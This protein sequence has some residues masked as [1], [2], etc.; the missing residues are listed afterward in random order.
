M[1]T[2]SAWRWRRGVEDKYH[3]R[4]WSQVVRWMSHK[5][6]MAQGEGLRLSFSP[7]NPRLREG[8]FFQAA[9][10]DVTGSTQE[11]LAARITA[12][13]GKTER[14]EFTPVTGG[15]GVFQAAFTPQEGGQH[16]VTLTGEKTSRRLETE[17]VVAQPR[18]E[19]LGQP[20]NPAILREMAELARGASGGVGDLDRLVS[21][22]ALLPE[23]E[24]IEQR[25]RLWA[26]PWWAG[27]LVLLLGIYWTARK[28]AGMI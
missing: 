1:G 12:P 28:I 17:I 9:I 6:H 2:D 18:R 8:I 15:W 4:F 25:L 11:K 5:R 16:K 27:F 10:Q 19:K 23:R 22:I 14:L 7:E 13:S 3:Y 24:P 21:Q 20:A 26:N